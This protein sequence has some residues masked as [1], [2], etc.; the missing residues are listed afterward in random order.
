MHYNA[1]LEIQQKAKELRK[2]ETDSEKLLWQKLKS[3]QLLGYKFRRQHPISQFIVD[4]YCHD[5]RLIIEVDGMVHN[6]QESREYDGNRT[7]ELEML[8]LEVLRFK[9]E[10]VESRI[11]KVVE[12]I[13]EFINKKR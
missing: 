10:E 6:K 2:T 8:G 9:N 3:K 13:I 5:L 7:Y 1:S 4:L 12:K 11:E